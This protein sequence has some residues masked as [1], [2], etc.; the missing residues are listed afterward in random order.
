MAWLQ[1]W[2]MPKIVQ[3]LGIEP[4]TSAVLRPRHDQLDHL[5]GCWRWRNLYMKPQ[6]QPL[7]FPTPSHSSTRYCIGHPQHCCYQWNILQRL[8]LHEFNM[9]SNIGFSISSCSH[10]ASSSGHKSAMCVHWLKIIVF[11]FTIYGVDTYDIIYY[12]V[13]NYF[14]KIPQQQFMDSNKTPVILK[15]NQEI[16]LT[17]SLTQSKVQNQD[18]YM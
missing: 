8:S 14:C 6:F 3:R 12:F 2:W 17:M 10:L 16:F 7:P 4:R 11:A 1:K 15:K 5:C 18:Q 9:S 13:C